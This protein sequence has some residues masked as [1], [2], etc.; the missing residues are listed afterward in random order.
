V[1]QL[2]P[3]FALCYSTRAGRADRRQIS[4]S[5]NWTVINQKDG[6][7][8]VS[9]NRCKCELKSEQEASQMQSSLPSQVR[10]LRKVVNRVAYIAWL[11]LG[12]V[13]MKLSVG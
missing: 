13:R 4:G 1:S 7:D 2:T 8:M 11:F 9:L 3:Q 12:N 6:L 10:V 5:L